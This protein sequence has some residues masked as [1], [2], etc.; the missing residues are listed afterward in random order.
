MIKKIY[1][2]Q[3][4]LEEFGHQVDD[5]E[6]FL[7]KTSGSEGNQKSVLLKTDSFIKNFKKYVESLGIDSNDKILITSKMTVEHPYAFG[8]HKVIDNIIFYE[9]IKYKLKEMKNV[10]VIFTTPSFFLNFKKFFKINTNQK[11]IFTGEEIPFTLKE[12]LKDFDIYQSFGMTES[13]NIGLKKMIDNDY[14]YI[15]DKIKIIDNYI[16]SPYLCSYIL[17]NNNLIKV[18]DKYKLSDNV[19]VNENKFSFLERNAEIAKINEEKVSLKMISNFLLSQKDINDLAIFKTK[20]NDLDQ[21]NLFIV[22]VLDKKS[23]EMMLVK[24]FNNINYIPKNI[25]KIDNIPITD[26]G[27]KDISKLINEYKI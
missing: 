17:E 13:L 19:V 12:E 8:L 15:D 14:M 24:E 21:I 3:S 20:K 7:F 10:D 6:Y 1:N 26:L 25:Y 4:F 27:K 5:H 2:K 16:Y 9:N 18:T 22:S 23:I 11:V